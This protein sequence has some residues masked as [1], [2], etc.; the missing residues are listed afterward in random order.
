M[1][2]FVVIFV[3]CILFF[4]GCADSA[5][6]SVSDI[7]GAQSNNV[8]LHTAELFAMDTYMTLKAYCA[9]DEPL[10][11][12]Q[13]IIESLEKELSVTSSDSDISRLNNAQGEEIVLNYDCAELIK[14]A[15]DLCE[16]TSGTLDITIYPILREWGFTTGDYKIP[17]PENIR[18]LLTNVN[19][20]AV[21]AAENSVQLPSGYMIDLGAVAKGYT[22]DKIISLFKENGITSAIISLGGNVHALGSKP[23]GSAWKIALTDPNLPQTYIGNLEIVDKAVITSGS[24]ERYFIGD[25]GTRY[26]HII[27]P[28]DGYPVNNGIASVTV[29]GDSG[30]LCDALST[31]LFV[32]GKEAAVEHWRKHC[33]FEMIIITDGGKVFLTEGIHNSFSLSRVYEKSKLEVIY[34]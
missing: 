21:S 16:R 18:S 20:S 15:L 22:S 10:N 4:C 13:A 3:C 27:S 11:S 5:H 17:V 34:R 33:D 30:V 31:A 1:R 24:Y 12:A 19:Y 25:D 2:K 8:S 28:F 26:C 6:E 9:D 7:S 32:M 23:D 14:N 29:I